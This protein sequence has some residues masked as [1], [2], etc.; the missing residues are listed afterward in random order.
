MMRVLDLIYPSKCVFCGSI[1]ESG[2]SGACLSCRRK[3]PY[4]TEPVCLQC[5]KPIADSRGT[6]CVNCARRETTALKQSAALW[7]Y[8]EDT[9]Q[10]MHDFK[11]GGCERDAV[12]YGREVMSHLR[13]RL[14][15]WDPDIVVPIPIHRRRERYR[16][17]NQAELL[18]REIGAGLGVSTELLL[19]R[20]RYTVPL[21]ELSASERKASLRRAFAVEEERF[22]PEVYRR[23]LLVDDIYTTG[24][25]LEACAGLLRE[26]GAAEVFA[27]CLCIGSDS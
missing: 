8:R 22:D 11:Y 2:D 12:Y 13:E 24:A 10:A 3:L 18:A 21:K 20:T 6:M 5:G 19:R 25:T 17:Y 26:S 4:V 23:I 14:R 15:E 1:L 27:I 16:G 9:K 7:V